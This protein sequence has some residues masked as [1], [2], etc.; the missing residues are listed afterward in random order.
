MASLSVSNNNFSLNLFKKISERNSEGNI[1]SPLS[2][3]SA[4]A[5]LE[6]KGNT[7]T[8]ILESLHLHKADGDIH[9]GFRKLLSELNKDKAPYALSL[10]NRLYEGARA[11]LC[12]TIKYYG[13]RLES[14]DFESNAE[15][16]RVNINNWVDKKTE[17]KLQDRL[18]KGAVN[19][20]NLLVNAIYFKSKP[21]K[22]MYQ[23]SMFCLTLIPEVN[24]QILEQSEHAPG[25]DRGQTGLEKLE[26]EITFCTI[27]CNVIHFML[28]PAKK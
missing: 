9:D 21:V 20:Q 23:E 16:A 11:F 25:R 4:L 28:R 2:I 6:A 3:S 13:A 17:G 8:Q 14:V 24:C 15:A 1:F 12:E 18:Q 7:V 22:I 5:I 10:A 19:N 27:V 26:R